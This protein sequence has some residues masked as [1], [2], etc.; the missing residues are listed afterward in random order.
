MTPRPRGLHALTAALSPDT[1]AYTMLTLA[2]VCMALNVVVGRAAHADIPP[3]G[4]SF[5]RWVFASALFLPFTWRRMREQWPLILAHWKILF[6][7]ALVMIPLGNSLV[8]VGL[9][10]T[11]ALN[12][13]LIPVSRPVII[14]VL[15]SFLFRGTV[16]RYQWLGIAIAL[17]GVITVLTRGDPSVL[18]T[19]D[20]NKGDLWLVA[21]S[22]GIACYQ[23]SIGRV[24]KE[25]HPAVLLQTTMMIGVAMMLPLYLLETHF[26]R[27]VEPTWPAIGAIAYVSVFPSIV[28][29]YFI[30]AGIQ[31]VGP[32]RMGI[33]NYLQPLFVAG[34]AVPVLGETMAWYHPVAL[35]LVAIG[36]VVSSRR[37][38][39]G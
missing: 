21:S 26:D 1:R 8:Y 6:I 5:W 12:G 30:N 13:G 19:L 38:G 35:V 15:A 23:T 10:D 24:P 27:P 32:A 2:F 34:I 37:R 20:F 22:I 25:I 7:V 33:F 17:A 36:I 31:A 16:T 18:A 3:L 39:G 28:A 9:Q 29:I 14:L 11:T 4:L